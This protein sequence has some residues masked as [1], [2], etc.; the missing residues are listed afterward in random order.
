MKI[1]IITFHASYN[2]GSILQCMALKQILEDKGEEVKIINFS[3]KE[4]QKLYSVFYKKINLKN[5]A[6]NILCIPG[7]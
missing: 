5:I 1:G 4:Q 7:Y 6:K 3:S 2:C